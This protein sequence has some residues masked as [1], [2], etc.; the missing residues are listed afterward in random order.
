MY[1]Q[2][3]SKEFIN[4][5][6]HA[7]KNA[8]NIV[9]VPD[10]KNNR[11]GLMARLWINGPKVTIVECEDPDLLLISVGTGSTSAVTK[12][13]VF[14]YDII[15]GKLDRSEIHKTFNDLWQDASEKEAAAIIVKCTEI[16][17]KNGS[18]NDGER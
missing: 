5:L 2:I 9:T 14:S 12:F 4:D 8:V 3:D 10:E 16:L 6:I 15:D 11:R 18:S 1:I 17:S 13:T 7:I